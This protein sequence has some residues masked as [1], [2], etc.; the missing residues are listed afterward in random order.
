METIIGVFN[1]VDDDMDSDQSDFELKT[2]T[3]CYEILTTRLCVVWVLPSLIQCGFVTKVSVVWLVTKLCVMS[4]I[5]EL[6]TIPNHVQCDGE[7]NRVSLCDYLYDLNPRVNRHVY[8]VHHIGD[9]KSSD[10]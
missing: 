7:N 4:H 5:T 2:L 10:V 1:Y 6:C 9:I 8:K 3:M